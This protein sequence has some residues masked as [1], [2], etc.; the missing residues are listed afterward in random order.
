MVDGD[1]EPVARATKT[2]DA[3]LIRYAPGANNMIVALAS[4]VSVSTIAVY[5]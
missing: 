2:A 5:L 1:C 3:D 4:A